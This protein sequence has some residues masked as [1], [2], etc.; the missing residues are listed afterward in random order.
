LR[1]TFPSLE[2]AILQTLAYSDI[3]DYPLTLDEIHKYLI[4]SATKEEIKALLE[5]V[6]QINFNE[7]Y[8]Y[9]AGRHALVHTRQARE[10]D[11][12]KIF[13][14]AMFYGKIIGKFPFIRMVALTG[15]LAMQNLSNAIDIDFMLITKPNR[16]WLA[17]AFA[18]TFGR[19]MRL[20]GDR[21]CINLLISENALHWKD[22]DLYSARE[23]CQMIPISGFDT[24][25]AF[26]VAN[27]WTQEILP[28]VSLNEKKSNQISWLQTLFEIPFL[29][30]LGDKLE[31]WAMDFQMKIISRQENNSN[32]TNFTPDICQG[33]F[34]QHKK[35]VMEMYEKKLKSLLHPLSSATT[36]K[37]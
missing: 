35:W 17:R 2:N 8:Y 4:V 7:G 34:H 16:L 36:A 21:I 15:S 28:N 20:L 13:S 10:K 33:N 3:F 23:I 22:H 26:R 32:E 29:G 11:S 12:K 25:C 19:F 30:K 24:Y 5:K 27:S 14:R 31:K 1:Q 6:N 37:E 9:L 18:V